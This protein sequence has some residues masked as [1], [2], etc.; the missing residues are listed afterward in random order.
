MERKKGIT[1]FEIERVILNPGQVVQGD[2][3]VVVA[4]AKRDDGLLRIPFIS[5]E[6]GVKILTVYW[7][8]I[9]RKTN[10]GKLR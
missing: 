7:T 5:T 8:S 6:T 3:N 10:E 4:Q 9:G 1:R 2:L